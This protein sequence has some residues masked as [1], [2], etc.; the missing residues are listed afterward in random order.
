MAGIDMKL[1]G[2][3]IFGMYK[4]FTAIKFAKIVYDKNQVEAMGGTIRVQS[5]KM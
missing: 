5:Q 2:H 1:N 4:T 3:K